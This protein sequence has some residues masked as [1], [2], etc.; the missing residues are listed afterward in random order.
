MAKKE[1]K[2]IHEINVTIEGKDWE[3]AG[4]QIILKKC[5][6]ILS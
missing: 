2:N 1:K 6:N 3:E 5:K 4:P